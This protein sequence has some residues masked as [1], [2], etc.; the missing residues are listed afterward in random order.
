MDLY[1]IKNDYLEVS[2]NRV[3]AELTHLIDISSGID[4][5]WDKSPAIWANSSPVLFPIVG[6]LMDDKFS[7]KGIDYQLSRHGFCRN[8][9]NF[10][11]VSQ[12]DSEITFELSWSSETLKDYPFKFQFQIT[13]LLGNS[14]LKIIHKVLNVDENNMY[15]SLGGHP[16]FYLSNDIE[17]NS[18]EFESD[19]DFVF[20]KLSKKGMRTNEKLMI[21]EERK[22]LEMTNSLFKDDALIFEKLNS[23]SLIL[24]NKNSTLR[25]KIIMGDFTQLGIWSKPGAPF[26]CL[27]PWLGMADHDTHNQKLEHK[28]FITQ[29]GTEKEFKAQYAIEVL[30]S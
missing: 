13:Y 22:D 4:L 21:Q 19:E 3:G 8:N 26:V 7:H 25:V 15:F 6:G 20:P 27:E 29:L 16:A 12:K 18:I 17:D 23:T 10:K 9:N 28:Q 30:K 24:K 5:M 14:V 2:I 11:V 1:S